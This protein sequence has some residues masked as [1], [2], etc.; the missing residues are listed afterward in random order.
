[1]EQPRSIP[2]PLVRTNQWFIVATVAAVWISGF[3][4]LLALPLLA[5]I[6]GLLFGFNP[7]MRFAKRFLRKQPSHYVPED[8]DQQQFNQ[9]IAV[10]CLLLGLAAYVAGWHM[11]A[12][13]FTGIV[14]LAALVA[15]LGFCIGCFIRYHWLQYRHR[16]HA[17]I[18]GK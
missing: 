14:A 15:I 4:W 10:I 1:M 11:A 2:R 7:V 16:K 3:Y 6:G 18:S 17:R 8:W 12:L 13:I 5:G 9:A